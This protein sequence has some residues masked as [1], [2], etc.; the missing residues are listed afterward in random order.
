MSLTSSL[1][2]PVSMTQIALM[3]RSWK[4]SSDTCG[5]DMARGISSLVFCIYIQYLLGGYKAP[6]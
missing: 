2:R 4:S 1:I 3:R 5:K 6:R